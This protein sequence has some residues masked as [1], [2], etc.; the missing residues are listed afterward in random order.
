MVGGYL[1][2]SVGVGG[3]GVDMISS[4]SATVVKT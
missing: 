3:G 2:A 4:I 1:G